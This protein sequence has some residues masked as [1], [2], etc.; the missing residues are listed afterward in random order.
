MRTAEGE[1]PVDYQIDT[2]EERSRTS[3]SGSL[4]G[5]LSFATD[6]TAGRLSLV[7][8]EAIDIVLIKPDDEGAD[9]RSA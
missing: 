4:T 5:D 8:G 7:S 6:Q 1:A 9:F 3:V 2:Y